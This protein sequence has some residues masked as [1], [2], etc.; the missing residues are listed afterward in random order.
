[1]KPAFIFSLLFGCVQLAHGRAVR[2]PTIAQLFEYAPLAVTGEVTSIEPLGIETTLSYPTLGGI[3]FHWLRVTCRVGTVLKG[4]FA[5]KSIDVAMLAVKK[6]PEKF[7]LI[8]G[9]LLLSPR[10][11]QKYV[12]F[13]APSSKKAVYA[14]I[15]APYDEANAIF[16]LDRKAREYDLSG[17][18]DQNYRE[19]RI[20]KNNFVWSL[21][22]E[23]GQFSKAGANE[24]AERY[25]RQIQ[26]NSQDLTIALEWK[27]QTN[28]Q[29]WSIDVPKDSPESKRK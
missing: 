23:D 20:E 21:V 7:G 16:I 2:E 1:M 26:T 3:T 15:L 22:T 11:G 4:K 18:R 6:S 12:M 19:H 14:S 10:R 8:N 27:I 24:V 5:G 13:L 28:A 25:K 9:P 17:V 29:G